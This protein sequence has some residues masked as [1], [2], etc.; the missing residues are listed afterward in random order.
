MDPARLLPHAPVRVAEKRQWFAQ[1][2]LLF[3]FERRHDDRAQLC[4]FVK[5]YEPIE[6]GL[7]LGVLPR[8]RRAVGHRMTT[9][10]W[11]RSGT[12]FDVVPADSILRPVVLQPH[13]TDPQL[14]VHNHLFDC[15]AV[16]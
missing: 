13:P 2:R 10:A 6:P 14:Q 7:C 3:S 9:L 15:Q 1:L 11:A 16:D 5:W 12:K 8:S 4:A